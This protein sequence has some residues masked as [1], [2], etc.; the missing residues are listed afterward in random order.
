MFAVAALL[1]SL[2]VASFVKWLVAV[3]LIVSSYAFCLSLPLAAIVGHRGLSSTGPASAKLVFA[4][5]IV[6]AW[7]SIVATVAFVYAAFVSL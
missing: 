6:G 3:T 5:N 7:A 2:A 1:S 4:A